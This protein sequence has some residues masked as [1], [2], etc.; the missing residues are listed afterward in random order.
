MLTD[1]DRSNYATPKFTSMLHRHGVKHLKIPEYNPSSAGRIERAQGVVDGMAQAALAYSG[2]SYSYYVMAYIHAAEVKNLLAH[3]SLDG[4][5]P[6]SRWTRRDFSHLYKF[7]RVWGCPAFV[8]RT[9]NQRIKHQ[10]KCWEGIY[11]GIGS[12]GYTFKI[13]DPMRMKVVDRRN[14]TFDEG[15]IEDR[16][17][18]SSR[19]KPFGLADMPSSYLDSYESDESDDELPTLGHDGELTYDLPNPKTGS[20]RDFPV[21]V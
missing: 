2:H 7:L 4:D 17:N 11:V 19:N 9:P 6:M 15:W 5:I 10:T 16:N 14:V 8:A 1:G 20:D 18:L 3:S 12:N 21:P 13:Y